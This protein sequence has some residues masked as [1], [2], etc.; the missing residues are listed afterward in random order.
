MKYSKII[1]ILLFLMLF[2]IPFS[3]AANGDY[4]LP[5]VTKYVEI[6]DDGSC[7]ITEEI[8]YDIEGSVNGT[9]RDIPIESNGNASITNLSVETP[10]FYNHVEVLDN[11]NN[12]ITHKSRFTDDIRIKIWLYEDKE[13]TR[14]VNNEK[15]PVII[16]YTYN[17]GVVIYDDVVDFYY[18]SWDRE[19]N[20]DVDVLKTFIKIPGDSSEAEFWNKPDSYVKSSAWNGNVLETVANNVPKNSTF[21]QRILL[22]T[23]FFKSTGNAK[24]VN[25]RQKESIE[26]Y[27]QDIV[28]KANFKD[29]I[30]QLF[31]GVMALIIAIAAGIYAVFGREPKIDYDREYEY[32]LPSDAKPLEV[33]TIFVGEVGY[34][35]KSAFG[36][37]I[38]DLLN[39]KYLE[40]IRSDSEDN[41]IRQS[42]KP[43]D[44]LVDYEV[45]CIDYLNKFSDSDGNISLSSISK[46]ETPKNYKDFMKKW[47]KK[48]EN[49]IPDSLKERYFDNKG[50]RIFRIFL[51]IVFMSSLITFLFSINN[52]L[53]SG[54]IAIAA[55]LLMIISFI[56][57]CVPN[58]FAGRWTPEGKEENDKW[59][60]F[61]KYISDYSLINERPPESVKIWGKYLIYASALE[62]ADKATSTM[63]KYFDM[64]EIDDYSIGADDVAFF[65]Y[66]GGISDMDLSFNSLDA[67]GSDFGSD[68]SGGSG[69]GF[70][71]GG[72]G[73]F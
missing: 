34:A 13:H 9:Y 48:V 65:A 15:V 56:L 16:N 2:L 51:L 30:Y 61:K 6:R 39:R 59:Q 67:S 8:I 21:K 55:I 36:T 37:V 27:E 33:H 26:K 44:D 1:V 35:Y 54:H 68:G 20:S 43:T 50:S 58:T 22:P 66:S 23:S 12:S 14:K 18:I 52:E 64:E 49:S 41:I 73:T 45:D 29:L 69:G 10:G 62:C 3:F 19:W 7:V 32:D 42:G 46:K 53:I 71:G 72:G 28:E 63:K 25:E 40:M 47:T 70:G 11:D 57:A 4:K 60:N 38:L 5:E 17:K 31:E 24:V